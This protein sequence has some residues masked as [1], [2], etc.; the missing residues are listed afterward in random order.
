M[1][2]FFQKSYQ[3]NV[4]RLRVEVEKDLDL[5]MEGSRDDLPAKISARALPSQT[6]PLQSRRRVSATQ[7]P[8]PSERRAH[9][10]RS[11]ARA[12]PGVAP[13]RALSMAPGPHPPQPG[14]LR[15]SRPRAFF[16]APPRG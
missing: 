3:N 6:Q 5:R 14:P 7:R 4:A 15:A 8:R 10:P 13:L 2:K 12:N 9:V 11:P 16:R 1:A